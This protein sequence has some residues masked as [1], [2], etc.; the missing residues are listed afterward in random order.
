MASIVEVRGFSEVQT[1]KPWSRS[2]CLFVDLCLHHYPYHLGQ[3]RDSSTKQPETIWQ[4]LCLMHYCFYV[5]LFS[6]LQKS[7]MIFK[8]CRYKMHF[9]PW[10]FYKNLQ[11]INVIKCLPSLSKALFKMLAVNKTEGIFSFVYTQYKDLSV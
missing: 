2:Q 7:H 3:F 8:S 11:N 6:C 5:N 1:F 9:L 10:H 4:P